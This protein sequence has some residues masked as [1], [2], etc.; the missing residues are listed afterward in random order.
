[1][2]AFL[3]VSASS[4]KPL[5]HL[6]KHRAPTPLRR[7]PSRRIEENTVST[8]DADDDV[9]HIPDLTLPEL[10]QVGDEILV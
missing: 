6:N 1:M 9:P 7:P 5:Q 3:L 4:P 8:R 2:T 10:Q